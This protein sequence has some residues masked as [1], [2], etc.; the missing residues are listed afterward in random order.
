MSEISEHETPFP[1]RKGTIFKFHYF[2]SWL[3]GDK[4]VAKH[5]SW[6]RS[7]YNYM[8]PYVSKFLRGAYVNYRDLDLGINK[9]GKISVIQASVWGIK[10]FKGN[11]QRL[12]KVKTE[13]D[14]GNF[15]RHEQS[16]PPLVLKSGQ[17]S[18]LFAAAPSPSESVMATLSLST[19]IVAVVTITVIV[20]LCPSPSSYHRWI[21]LSS[22][23]R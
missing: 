4:N 1:H 21:P 17:S 6:I 22:L 7:L 18:Q 11:F 19:V 3:D 8:T 14:P 15:F 23:Y 2:T 12:V 10:Y 20:Q 5:M 9:K 16:I 13:V